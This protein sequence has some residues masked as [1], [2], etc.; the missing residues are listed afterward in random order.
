MT[1]AEVRAM[2]AGVHEE[3]EN[4]DWESC[5]VAEDEMLVAVL[6]AIADG[7]CDSPAECAELALSTQKLGFH[8]W[9][10]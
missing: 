1:P 6:R 3:A 5:H 4:G 9:Y 8:R 2:L 10:A 7:S